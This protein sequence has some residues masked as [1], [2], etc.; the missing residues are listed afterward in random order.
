MEYKTMLILSTKNS[1]APVLYPAG[2]DT[3]LMRAARLWDTFFRE[4]GQEVVKSKDGKKPEFPVK[5]AVIAFETETN[6]PLAKE[7]GLDLSKLEDARDEAHVIT[8]RLWKG[9]PLVLIVGKTVEGTDAGAAYLLSKVVCEID[10][11]RNIWTVSCP[12]INIFRQPFFRGREATLCPT[13]RVQGPESKVNYENWEKTRLEQYPVYLKNCGFNSVQL[14]ELIIYNASSGSWLGGYRGGAQ[15]KTIEEIQQVLYTL[16][17]AAHAAG[18][19]VSQYI[20]G[21]PADG[22]KWAD[23]N[24]RP[25]REEFYRELA[26]RYGTK[27]DHIITHWVDEGHE[28]G[29]HTPLEATSFI[30][31]EYQKYN[32]KVKV[33]CDTWFNPGLYDGI[34]DEKY[35]PKEVAIAIERWYNDARAEQIAKTERKI[36]IWGWYLSDFEMTYGSHLYAKTLDKYFAELPELANELVDWISLEQCFHALPSQINLY[37]VGRKMW[38]PKAPLA[39]IM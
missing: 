35:A 16:S 26:R 2:E 6:C 25:L 31:R 10:D 9:S 36:G 22:Y 7:I 11:N 39:E 30:Y 24:T 5:G 13:G 29:F 15:G 27:I 3:V 28:R 38:E 34:E 33:T 17:D 1:V 21:S 12:L 37:I 23:P 19:S 4:R 32:P 14:M 18:L 20:W 8:A